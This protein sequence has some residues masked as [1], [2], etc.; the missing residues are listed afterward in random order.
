MK[1]TGPE[2]RQPGMYDPIKAADDCCIPDFGPT[3]TQQSQAED[4]DINTIVRRFGLTGKLPDD[5]R[6]PTYADYD[7]V[8][9]FHTAMNAVTAAHSQFMRMP[10]EIRGRFDNDPQKFVE[11]CED[12]ANLEILRT[13]GLAKALEE[14]PGR[15]AGAAGVE[16]AGGEKSAPGGSGDGITSSPD[17]GVSRQR[18]TGTVIT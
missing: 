4:A 17:G 14:A 13:M 10:A 18:S 15:A 9:D 5:I 1:Y 8:D 7:Q 11:F 2:I 12:P 6:T 3:K 16:S